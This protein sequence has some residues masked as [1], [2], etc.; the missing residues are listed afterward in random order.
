MP[1]M[2]G[3]SCDETDVTESAQSPTT[4]A[5]LQMPVSAIAGLHGKDAEQFEEYAETCQRA[6]PSM[7]CWT[8]AGDVLIGC[9]TGELLKVIMVESITKQRPLNK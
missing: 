2:A 8:P 4:K 6:V 3:E 5:S 7:H 1:P 9:S